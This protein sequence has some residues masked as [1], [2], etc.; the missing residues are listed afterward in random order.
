MVSY[1]CDISD[2]LK[3]LF[4]DLGIWSCEVVDNPVVQGYL[5]AVA[6]QPAMYLTATSTS[7]EAEEATSGSVSKPA[8]QPL[9]AQTHSSP[10]QTPSSVPPTNSPS[11]ASST[12]DTLS[13]SAP[14]ALP[15]PEDN[16]SVG[17]ET[18]FVETAG[19]AQPV[20]E[21]SAYVKGSSTTTYL[22]VVTTSTN[23][24]GSVAVVMNLA[25]ATPTVTSFTNV[26]GDTVISTSFSI[27]GSPTPSVPIAVLPEIL[28]YTNAQGSVADSTGVNAL[29]ADTFTSTNANGEAIVSTGLST[30]PISTSIPTVISSVD[31]EGKLTSST[32][33][34][35][36]ITFATTNDQ[37]S[38]SIAT[39]PLPFASDRATL[40]STP[41]LTSPPTIT[42]G[43]QTVTANSLNQYLIGRQTLTT[44]GVIT[45]S[46]TRLSLSPDQNPFL[47]GTSV[48]NLAPTNPP[49]LTIGSQTCTAKSLNQYLISGQ[50]LTAGGVVTVSGT[51]ISLVSDE[52][53]VEVG[54]S[55]DMLGNYPPGTTGSVVNETNGPTVFTGGAE[56]TRTI[57]GITF[58]AAMV[59]LGMKTI[60]HL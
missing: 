23:A 29:I 12:S 52:T 21:A 48:E 1:N 35:L 38:Q 36:A 28:S 47:V 49:A 19:Q 8:A 53:A 24:Q 7:T 54:T 42:I 37:G 2:V 51:P 3:P 39:S 44:G 5:P 10:R 20:N 17:A 15:P 55:T 31:A 6:H 60:I 34:L 41:I 50:T 43:S 4:P 40:P 9:G 45:L 14:P 58:K 57:Y 13:Q 25:A 16:T 22:P 59:I 46:S 11:P 33:Y 32:S 30:L 18:P 26:A 27:I 56:S